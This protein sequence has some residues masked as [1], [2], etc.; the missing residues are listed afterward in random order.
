MPEPYSAERDPVPPS[1]HALRD[2]LVLVQDRLELR[3]GGAP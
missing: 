3:D 2:A 1:R